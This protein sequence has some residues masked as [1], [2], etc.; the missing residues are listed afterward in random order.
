[1]HFRVSAAA[2][3]WADIGVAR[4]LGG[5]KTRQGGFRV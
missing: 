5:V 1:M 3:P 4:G 2:R